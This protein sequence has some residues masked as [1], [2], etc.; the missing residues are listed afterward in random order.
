MDLIQCLN[1]FNRL[2]DDL[3]SIL[4]NNARKAFL[5]FIGWQPTFMKFTP[6]VSHT[7]KYSFQPV[8]VYLS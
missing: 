2:N 1:D 8:L 5:Y 4:L 3:L 7:F 6:Y